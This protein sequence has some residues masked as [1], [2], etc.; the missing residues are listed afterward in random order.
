VIAFEFNEE[1]AI[2]LATLGMESLLQPAKIV[3]DTVQR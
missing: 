2:L 1:F 3:V